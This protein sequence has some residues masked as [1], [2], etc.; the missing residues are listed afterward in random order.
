MLCFSGFFAG[1]YSQFLPSLALA[2][3]V[4]AGW[5]FNPVKNLN[6][7]L[8]QAGFPEM[9][10]SGFFT[11][12][13]GGFIDLPRKNNYLRIG[14]FGNGF[15]SKK[16][17]QYNDTLKKDANYSLGEGGFSLEFVVPLGKIVDISFGSQFSTGTLKLELYQYGSDFGNYNTI[18]GELEQNGSTTNLARVYKSRF[19]TVQ[20]KVG[21][22]ILMRKFM[23]LKIDCGYQ[24]GGQNTWRVD[25]DVEVKN[26]PKGIEAKG[27]VINVGLNFGLFIKE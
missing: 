4:S 12:G 8:K 1:S 23:Y 5:H 7:E 14:G 25:N 22:G 21:I 18:F 24:I 13:G 3:G 15:T 20:P 16:S 19:Y 26:F 6:A 11:L 27:L 2:G 9:S 17:K 10:E